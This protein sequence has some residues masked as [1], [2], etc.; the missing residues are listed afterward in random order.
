MGKG[1]QMAY[2]TSNFAQ[3]APPDRRAAF[4]F[5]GD[6][7]IILD[8][9]AACAR[10]RCALADRCAI[11]RAH[12]RAGWFAGASAERVDGAA[13]R[14][15][16]RRSWSG[17]KVDDGVEVDLVFDDITRPRAGAV[18]AIDRIGSAASFRS[19]L[20]SDEDGACAAAR[21]DRR[22]PL[23]GGAWPARAAR[24]TR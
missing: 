12:R 11:R 17:C 5:A 4:R 2:S 1:R 24:T 14:A 21:I 9:R 3:N 7:S 15:L 23:S 10:A 8:E 20:H 19:Q 22:I 13:V 18:E 16:S 6:F